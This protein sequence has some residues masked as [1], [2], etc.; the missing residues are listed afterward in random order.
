MQGSTSPFACAPEECLRL[1]AADRARAL[2]VAQLVHDLR[3][4]LNGILGIVQLL[5]ADAQDP[6][7]PRH[8]RRLAVLRD[9]GDDMLAIVEDVLD[10]SRDIHLRR[11]LPCRPI[12]L[13]GLVQAALALIEP[14]A[15]AAGITLDCALPAELPALGEPRAVGR[16]LLNLL[17]N[18]LLHNRPQGRIS[19]SVGAPADERGGTVEL[20]IADTGPGMDAAQ[21]RRAFRPYQ[22]GDAAVRGVPGTG[23]GLPSCQALVQALGGALAMASVPGVGTTATLRLQAPCGAAASPAGDRSGRVPG[24][25]PLNRA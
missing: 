1:P 8:L 21:L 19:I 15:A 20:R 10:A 6:L 12:E 25:A 3:T 9:A 24:P 23:L 2:D 5:M 13:V 7:P 16:V 18:A 11:A 22:R 14:R 4:P 17:T